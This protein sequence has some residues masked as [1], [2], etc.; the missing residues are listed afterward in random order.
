MKNLVSLLV[1]LTNWIEVQT[2]RERKMQMDKKKRFSLL[3]DQ[4]HLLCAICV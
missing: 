1:T 4:M 2:D 3:S